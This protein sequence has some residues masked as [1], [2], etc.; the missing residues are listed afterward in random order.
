M[1]NLNSDPS[2]ANAE[3]T[4]TDKTILTASTDIEQ[5]LLL[6]SILHE[7]TTSRRLMAKDDWLKIHSKLIDFAIN[8]LY[9]I[10]GE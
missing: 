2:T 10:G 1:K 4:K 9:Q 3:T 7:L 6:K 8:S 5:L